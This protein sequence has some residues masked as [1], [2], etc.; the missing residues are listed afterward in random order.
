M[1]T[2]PKLFNIYISDLFRKMNQQQSQTSVLAFTDDIIIYNANKYVSKMQKNFD[3]IQSYVDSWKLRTNY[4]KC[5]VIL[6]K[7]SLDKCNK[8]VKKNWRKFYIKT[9]DNIQITYQKLVRYLGFHLTYNLNQS[10]KSL[11]DI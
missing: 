11:Y 3:E 5:E 9:R 1:V 10:P 4:S 2:A 8:F 7:N 6:F